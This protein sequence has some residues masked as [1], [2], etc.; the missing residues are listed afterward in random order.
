[1]GPVPIVVHLLPKSL[2]IP[3]TQRK[4]K[5]GV[6]GRDVRGVTLAIL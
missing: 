5:D 3:G 2:S 6:R 1:M 4:G